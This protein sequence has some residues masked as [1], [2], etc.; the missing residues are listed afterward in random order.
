MAQPEL[1]R[2]ARRIRDLTRRAVHASPAGAGFSHWRAAMVAV[3]AG[4]FM[5]IVGPFGTIEAPLGPRFVYWIG[6]LAAGTALANTIGRLAVR[7]DLFERRPWIWALLVTAVITPPMTIVVWLA[8][9]WVFFKSFRPEAALGYAV[10]VFVVSA[11]MLTITV[12]TQKTPALTHAAPREAAPPAFLERLPPRLRGA[13][14]YAVRA[15]D[16]YLRLYTSRGEDIILMRLADALIEL[17]GLEGARV[18]RSWW[19]ARSAVIDA[20]RGNGRAAF[21]LPGG[22]VAPVSRTY[23]AALRAAGWY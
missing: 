3:L 8:S 4:T 23:A 5:A 6:L 21:T 10:P 11:A 9:S 17:E 22:V 19:V 12:L 14:L 13:D 18:H 20:D 1:R 2:W 7:F 15:E 16:H